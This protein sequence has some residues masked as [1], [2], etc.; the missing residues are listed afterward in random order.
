[1]ATTGL[2]A[3]RAQPGF[4]P[5][6]TARVMA[7]QLVLAAAMLGLRLP[8]PTGYL[9]AVAV[10]C[11][12]P[13]VLWPVSLPRRRTRAAD[14]TDAT[15]ALAALAPRLHIA[16]VTERDTEYGVGFD[17]RG[18]FAG[19]AL[20]SGP[21][22]P[23]GLSS[24]TLGAVG[25]VLLDPHITVSAV[26]IV[27]HLVPSPSAE[28]EPDAACIE[29][30]RELLGDDSVVSHRTTWLAVRLDVDTAVTVAGERG[31]GVPGARRAV[32][33][34]AGRLRKRLTDAGVSHRVLGADSLRVALTHSVSGETISAALAQ[35]AEEHP[36][37]WRLGALAQVSFGVTGRIRDV[38]SLR[39]LWSAM[40]MVSASFSTVSVTLRPLRRGDTTEPGAVL[41]T[42]LRVAFDDEVDD[43][44][45]DEVTQLATACGIRLRRFD[46]RQA[47]ATYAS[48][49]TGGGYPGR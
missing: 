24:A 36:H 5:V 43:G 23:G 48:A 11:L 49:P 45:P 47:A 13:V 44:I 25:A 7:A 31:G 9:T 1:M 33:A 35:R 18:W 22:A 41:H 40:G 3:H 15:D 14:T 26:Q 20:E 16:A 19:I 42:M 29:S 38:E 34:V 6:S 39:R 21:D 12:L 37:L 4:G 10:G 27:E 28:L 46:R 8:A 30:Y 2:T 17:G 32:T